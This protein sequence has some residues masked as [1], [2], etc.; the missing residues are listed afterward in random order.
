MMKMKFL[1]VGGGSMGKRRIRCLLANGIQSDQI[2]VVELLE[3]RR[4]EVE[5]KH[6]VKGFGRLEDGL[7]WDPA[8]VIVSVPG[9]YHM[10]VCLAATRAGKH[11]FCEVPLS[12]SLE[13]TE[14]LETLVK[15][16]GLVMAPGCQPV[17]HP[18]LKRASEW[19][20]DPSFGKVLMVNYETGQYLPD[21]HPYEDYRKF[22]ASS[23]RMGGGNLDV[24]AQEMNVLRLLI[25]EAPGEVYCRASKLSTLEI[26]GSDCQQILAKTDSGISMFLHFDLI[27][28]SGFA[29]HRIISEQG[30]IALDHTQARRFL[31]TTKSWETFTPP[32]GFKYEECYINEIGCF[33]RCIEG[34]E[35]WPVPLEVA[36]G[37]VKFL[38]AIQKSASQQKMVILSESVEMV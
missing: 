19:I 5:H 32:D 24:I 3:D 16:N 33:I 28:R 11:V 14:E 35:Q 9:A 29:S 21:W 34:K 23:A 15:R 27:Q 10:P 36:V 25:G 7:A 30:T 37:T 22:Y 20:R 12:T 17:F 4:A 38:L 6:D 2:R 26:D 8:G 18:V 31:A 13:G 1:V